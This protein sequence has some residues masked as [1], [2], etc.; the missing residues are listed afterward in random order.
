MDL[1]D[2]Q[3]TAAV[4]FLVH[5]LQM[6]HAIMPRTRGTAAAAAAAAA[7]KQQQ[8]L[9]LRLAQLLMLHAA[10]HTAAAV[11]LCG[12][13]SKLEPA[14]VNAAWGI[15]AV[16]AA[17]AA[18]AGPGAEALVTAATQQQQ[19][20]K[21]QQQW[22]E[23]YFHSAPAVA[24]A[25][26][27]LVQQQLSSVVL[28]LGG[29]SALGLTPTAPQ[30]GLAAT[31][32]STK[33][34]HVI[35]MG[36]ESFSPEQQLQQG[37]GGQAVAQLM[38]LVLS[39][40]GLRMVLTQC[41]RFR[42][43]AQEAAALAQYVQQQQ[44]QED[45]VVVA[46]WLFAAAALLLQLHKLSL[47]QAKTRLGIEFR[48]LL[49][50]QQQQQLEGGNPASQTLT[51]LPSSSSSSSVAADALYAAALSHLDD[52]I[53][54]LS[55][56]TVRDLITTAQPAAPAAAAAA[57]AAIDSGSSQ[58]QQQAALAAADS[59]WRGL[60]R[61]SASVSLHLPLQRFTA[62]GV[63]GV[64][65]TLTHTPTTAA[66]AAARDVS[67]AAAAAAVG[68]EQQQW[69]HL[70]LQGLKGLPCSCFSVPAFSTSLIGSMIR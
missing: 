7:G 20:H 29:P 42:V 30:Q 60:L 64:L 22:V 34:Q 35:V 66:A 39:G 43:A 61:G 65:G 59:R 11:L 40:Q 12:P 58:G 27:K 50:Q 19:Q 2:T 52:V 8:Q 51:T 45:V 31:P 54:D 69:E 48:S 15:A 62:A 9:Q 16:A 41:V 57:A 26:D 70:L 56:S 18:A 13:T 32:A 63:R 67:R 53:Q 46:A 44:Q 4:L 37:L 6:L 68:S 33:P 21:Q 24:A 1:M 25:V 38:G 3:V 17:T 47:Q 49:L 55:D 28:Q 14:A 36:G 23:Q 10:Q 5:L